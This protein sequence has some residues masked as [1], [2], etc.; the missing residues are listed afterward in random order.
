MLVYERGSEMVTKIFYEEGF[1]KI[2]SDVGM[3]A[4]LQITRYPT[5]M[6]GGIESNLEKLKL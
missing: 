6:A 3:Q 5:A 1:R 4:L 2:M